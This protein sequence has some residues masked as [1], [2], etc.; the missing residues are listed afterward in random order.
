MK[1][2][3]SIIAIVIGVLVG[4][5]VIGMIKACGHVIYPQPEG[6]GKMIMDPDVTRQAKFEAIQALPIGALVAVLIAWMSGAFIGGGTAAA[7]ASCCRGLHAGII[8]ALVLLASVM[9]MMMVPHPDWM[10]LGG[11][12]TPLPLSLLAGMAASKLFPPREA[13]LV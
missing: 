4:M 5:L 9:M 7:I 3:R 13:T 1:M 8:G 12:A 10:I 6:F 2:L 11:L